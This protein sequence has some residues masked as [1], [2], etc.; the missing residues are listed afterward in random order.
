[1][2]K[3]LFVILFI[4]C[5]IEI[6]SQTINQNQSRE[7]WVLVWND[8]TKQIIMIVEPNHLTTT[9]YRLEEFTT[10]ESLRQFIIDN[11][12]KEESYD[13]FNQRI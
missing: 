9:I 13:T 1:M 3:F 11:N 5:F 8:M 10:E 6:K 7:T 4:I 12:L 2:K